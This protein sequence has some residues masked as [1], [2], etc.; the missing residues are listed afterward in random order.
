MKSLVVLVALLVPASAAADEL[1]RAEWT[2]ILQ[3]T[4]VIVEGETTIE[5]PRDVGAVDE[6]TI[7]VESGSISFDEV[8]IVDGGSTLERLMDVTLDDNN[9]RKAIDLGKSRRHLERVV[10]NVTA[11]HGAVSIA[12]YAHGGLS[13]DPARLVNTSPSAMTENGWTL[14]GEDDVDVV[15]DEIVVTRKRSTWSK[16]AIVVE[17][18]EITVQTIELTFRGK[19]RKPQRSD[20]YE[21][22]GHGEAQVVEI[23]GRRRGIS[24]IRLQYRKH[25]TSASTQVQV[26]AR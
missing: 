24:K 11:L 16:I 17:S 1:D 5:I 2:R 26:W 23:R 7:V 13:R 12:L 22:L 10:V 4:T 20:L 19:A 18:A 9:P 14:L 6:L 21:D 8:S 3:S 25:D 15:D